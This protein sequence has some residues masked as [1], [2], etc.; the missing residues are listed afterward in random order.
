M[1]G[2]LRWHVILFTVSSENFIKRVFFYTQVVTFDRM[3]TEYTL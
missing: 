1:I 3:K 2:M